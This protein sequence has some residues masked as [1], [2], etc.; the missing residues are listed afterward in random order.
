MK[1][2]N[3]KLEGYYHGTSPNSS[4][5]LRDPTIL[6][7][8]FTASGGASGSGDA[9][10]FMSSAAR[11]SA[12][13]IVGRKGDVT[14]VVPFNKKA[15]HAG[16]SIWRG[17]SN[18]NDYS[19]G[20][21]VDNWGKLVKTA[22]GKIRSWTKEEVSASDCA[23]MKHKNEDRE[24]Y[25][26]LYEEKQLE[27]LEEV[28]RTIL[29]KYPSIKEIVGH[30]DIAPG[31]KTDPGPAFPMSRFRSLVNGRGNR[32]VIRRR[33]TANLNERGGPGTHFDIIRTISKGTLVNV[34][35]D[36]PGAWA[37]LD[38]GGWVNDTYLA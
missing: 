6:V 34:V 29:A 31:R 17:V 10:Y 19:I 25:W 2:L 12:H 24:H 37:Q 22:D 13:V 30:D 36:Q 3:H 4:G 32:D 38:T 18:C 15:W 26:E 35:Y 20:I 9:N 8:H 23:L 11:A 14:Q 27:A 1:I 5:V 16:K 7:I 28:V 33:T 21:E